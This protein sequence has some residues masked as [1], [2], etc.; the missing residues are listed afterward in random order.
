MKEDFNAAWEKYVNKGGRHR[1]DIPDL[2]HHDNYKCKKQT[3][4]T[5]VFHVCHQM[6]ILARKVTSLDP[7]VHGFIKSAISILHKIRFA[8]DMY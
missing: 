1:E 8:Y 4:E 3:G 6:K 5:C 7:E 2:Y